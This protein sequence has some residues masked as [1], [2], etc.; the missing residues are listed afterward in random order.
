M[1]KAGPGLPDLLSLSLSTDRNC[2]HFIHSGR[3]VPERTSLTR[4]PAKAFPLLCHSEFP[5]ASTPSLAAYPTWSPG[6]EWEGLAVWRGKWP[7]IP[8]REESPPDAL[9]ARFVVIRR[10]SHWWVVGRRGGGGDVPAR[11]RHQPASLLARSCR[12]VGRK[13]VGQGLSRTCGDSV[14]LPAVLAW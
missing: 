12:E 5:R 8:G 9:M 13:A 3:V 11:G 2:A 1:L 10:G 7:E 6:M 14:T 4:S